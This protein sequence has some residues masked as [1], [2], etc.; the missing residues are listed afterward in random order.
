MLRKISTGVNKEHITHH[1]VAIVASLTDYLGVACSLS[2]CT[3]LIY[4]TE[5]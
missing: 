1:Y 5:L 3:K 4:K 2:E